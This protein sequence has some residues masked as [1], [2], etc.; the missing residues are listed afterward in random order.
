MK[1]TDY[2]TCP[3]CGERMIHQSDF[4]FEEAGYEGQGVGSFLTC[5]NCDTS[6]EIC[7]PEK[8]EVEQ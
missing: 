5:P 7:V 2:F 4:S 8:E 3:N 1:K 6:V